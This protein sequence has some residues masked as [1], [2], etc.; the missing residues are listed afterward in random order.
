MYHWGNIRI[1]KIAVSVQLV[2]QIIRISI[3]ECCNSFY[4]QVTKK[5]KQKNK[6][7][8]KNKSITKIYMK[9]ITLLS[10]GQNIAIFLFL[11]KKHV[12]RILNRNA[13]ANI[14]CVYSLEAPLKGASNEYTQHI[15]YGEIRNMRTNNISFFYGAIRQNAYLHIAI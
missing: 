12:L 4:A 7:K 15:F 9:C 13:F 11:H 10:Y 14:C 5:K 3:S 2:N 1:G 8:T 6:K